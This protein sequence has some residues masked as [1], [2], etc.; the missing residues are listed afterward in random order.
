M[1]TVTCL[2]ILIV[3]GACT[4]PSKKDI[5]GR[6]GQILQ[7]ADSVLIVSHEPTDGIDLY[8]EQTGKS[9][10][11]A[12][13]LI[14]NRLNEQIIKESFRVTGPQLDTLA[15]ILARPKVDRKI[16]TGRCFIP[17]HAIVV[18]NGK[19]ISYADI[20]FRCRRIISSG[21]VNL[22]E[23]DFDDQKWKELLAFTRVM[24]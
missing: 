8:D 15:R 9:S 21:K 24:E 6:Y 23:G 19:N 1:K 18:Y 4:K 20:C 22:F 12:P 13:L 14:A 3:V 17:Q 7:N 16:K 11:P 5:G 10:K 2:L